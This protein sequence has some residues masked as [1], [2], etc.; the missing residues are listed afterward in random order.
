MGGIPYQYF[1]VRAVPRPERE[2]FVNVGV[3]LY[4]E[5]FDTLLVGQHVDADR[6]RALDPAVDIEACRPR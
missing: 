6:L 2:E 4:A 3:V 5:E 1:V